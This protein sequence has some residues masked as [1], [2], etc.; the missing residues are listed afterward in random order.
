VIV[1]A[2]PGAAWRRQVWLSAHRPL[3]DESR[4]VFEG[5][6]TVRRI[7]LET[8]RSLPPWVRW[9]CIEGIQWIEVGRD[10]SAWAGGAAL[11]RG[12][13][14][15]GGHRIALC[16]NVADADLPGLIGHEVSHRIRKNV[17]STTPAPSTFAHA[18][19][20]AARVL[21]SSQAHD[22]DP[23]LDRAVWIGQHVTEELR[24]DAQ[25]RDEWGLPWRGHDPDMLRRIFAR[26][27][28]EAARLA[29][30][31]AIEHDET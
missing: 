4:L 11:A 27:Y 9:F 17:Q 18:D 20:L 28:D 6:D 15:E 26:Q 16:G 12:I 29:R 31:A 30:L 2:T 25:A 19:L 22:A 24:A 7:V 14:G 1:P 21:V 3:A 5:D 10:C 23:E 8:L 13:P